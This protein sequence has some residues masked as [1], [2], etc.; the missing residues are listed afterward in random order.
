MGLAHTAGIS[1]SLCEQNKRNLIKKGKICK[2]P[3]ENGL[4][5]T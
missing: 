2:F 3:Q 4:M 1:S 5:E